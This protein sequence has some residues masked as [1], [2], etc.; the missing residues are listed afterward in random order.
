MT[1]CAADEREMD[2]NDE[3]SL[4]QPPSRGAILSHQHSEHSN[5]TIYAVSLGSKCNF[6]L[7]PRRRH[8]PR[9]ENIIERVCQMCIAIGPGWHRV[10]F[11]VHRAISNRVLNFTFSSRCAHMAVLIRSACMP[12]C[13]A[14]CS[15]PIDASAHRKSTRSRADS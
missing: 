14:P 3:F 7:L 1:L 9:D 2:F 11:P 6:K 12:L 4:R 15:D 5:D 8:Q 10:M 13:F